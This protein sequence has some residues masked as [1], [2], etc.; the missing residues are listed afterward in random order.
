M[1]QGRVPEDVRESYHAAA[2]AT[3]VSL[4][5]YLEKLAEY[6]DENNAWPAIPKPLPRA[7]TLD[8]ESLEASTAA[9]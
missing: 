8:L 6:L 2:N 1:L 4:A 5:Y 9:A 7:E 3:G